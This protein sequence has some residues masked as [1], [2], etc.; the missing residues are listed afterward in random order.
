MATLKPIRNHILF[1]FEEKQT[2]H[3]GIAQ[4]KEE[5]DWGFEYAN[6]TE[7]M[8][9][10]RWVTVTHVG[11]EVPDYIKPGMRVCVDKLKWTN[12]FEFEGEK[13]WRT[14][15]DCILLIDETVVPA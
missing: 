3:M 11:H 6:T 7:G 9:T 1:Q 14:D 12:D 10:G 2:K 15:S 4:F 13:Y 8:E 5:T